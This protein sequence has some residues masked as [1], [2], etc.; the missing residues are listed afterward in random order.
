FAH[1]GYHGYYALDF[2][3]MDQS[4]GTID[5]MREFVD[6]A[7]EKGI[8]VVLDV[9]MNH[10][11]YPTLVDMEKFS[12]GD[13]GGLSGDWVPN[14]NKGENW[15]THNDIMDKTNEVAWASWWGKD[16][17]RADGTAG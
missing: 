5:E 16:W 15:H 6:L 12:Y 2:T 8:R 4:I 1:Y 11:A 7:H 10:V 14:E 3:S 13:S 17:I 9:V